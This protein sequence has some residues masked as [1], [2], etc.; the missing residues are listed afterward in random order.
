M[1][2]CVQA[3]AN[4][5]RQPEGGAWD[6][7]D[8][9]AHAR[10]ILAV[11]CTI[12][13]CLNPTFFGGDAGTSRLLILVYL[14]YSLFNLIMI[15][16]HRHFGFWGLCLH[17]AEVII[18]SLISLIAMST[19]GAQSPLLGF[20][21][22]VVLAAACKWGFNGALLTSCVCMIFLFSGLM[23]PFSWSGLVP[24]LISGTDSFI[25]MMALSASLVS[26][27]CF[28]GLLVERDKKRFGDAVAT[29]RLVRNAIVEPN[30]RSAIG[31]T[32]IAVREHFDADQVRLAVQQIRGERA[33]AWEVTRPTGKNG[34][35][36]QSWKLTESARGAWFAAPPDGI[37]RW[38]EAGGVRAV[39]QLRVWGGRNQKGGAQSTLPPGLSSISASAR[40]SNG[41]YDLHIV[42]EHHSPIVGSWSL[43]ATSFSFEGKWL[44]RI[45][46]LDPR[47][48]S[49]PNSEVRFLGA[50]VREVG[51]A[52]YSKYLVG[53]LRSRAQATE[54]TRI[55]QELHDGIVQSLLGLE[56]E[57]D[58]LCRPH[59]DSCRPAC[60]LLE[61]RR[62][63]QLLHRE[64][65][66]L[67]EAMQRVRPIE[68]EPL[69]LMDCMAATVE[70]FRGDFEIS[71]SFVVESQDVSLPPRVCSELVSIL[72]EALVNA[73]KHSGARK[74]SVRFAR[75]NGHWKLRVE[76]DGA[77]MGFTGCLST[78]EPDPSHKCPAVIEERVRSIG[79]ELVIQ[80]VEGSG[81]VVEI[82]VPSHYDG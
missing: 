51:P 9:L 70:K 38:L 13:V 33:V 34:N 57:M 48:G 22:F 82:M 19:G 55:A 12:A 25:A 53:R 62:I 46:V 74:V 72:Q 60:L 75:E 5:L 8:F 16:L 80:S 39:D 79:G 7:E 78:A 67:R 32:L 64:V 4:P 66:D 28:L 20:Y 47:R 30:L 31:N 52:L 2:A 43:L 6:R 27:A 37:R 81:A 59:S 63:Q 45:T 71:T 18:I 1:G 73:R 29:T 24:R 61:M 58:L 41:L 65:A 17:A 54:R 36:V 10:L 21:L 42:N 3:S 56:I 11:V 23:I 26:L 50:L 69:R 40:S 77:G 35:G 44:G 76:D 49:D 15:R 14:I 68:V